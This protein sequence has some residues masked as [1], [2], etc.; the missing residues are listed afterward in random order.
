[1]DPV[2]AGENALGEY[3]LISLDK[4]LY[5]AQAIM[6]T[7]YALTDDFYIHVTRTEANDHFAVYFYNKKNELTSS[8]AVATQLFMDLLL[9]NQL[10]QIVHQQ[11]N[12]IRE[13]IV[14]KAFS[15]ITSFVDKPASV[16]TDE[17][18]NSSVR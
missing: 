9:E 10:R 3:F 18:L 15:P 17:I 13:E 14:K 8:P 11:T 6:K 2:V 5:S 4:E 1:M 16:E 12:T 7:C